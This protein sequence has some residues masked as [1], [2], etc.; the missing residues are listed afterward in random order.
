[1]SRRKG[2]LLHEAPKRDLLSSTEDYYSTDEA[3]QLL[4]EPRHTLA[5]WR[6]QDEG[7][8]YV[9]TVPVGPNSIWYPIDDFT[10]GPRSTRPYTAEDCQPAP[11]SMEGSSPADT[12]AQWSTSRSR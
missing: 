10:T 7:P 2:P 11:S 9:R 5:N 12:S 8:P 3:A 1:M 4:D 6:H